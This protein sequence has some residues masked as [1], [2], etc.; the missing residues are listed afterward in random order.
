MSNHSRRHFLSSAAGTIAALSVLGA[1]PAQAE[2][3]LPPLPED[4]P[5]AKALGYVDDVAKVP[6]GEPMLKPDAICAN[7][8]HYKGTETDPV[9]PCALFPGWSVPDRAWCKAWVIKPV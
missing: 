1:G 4:N 8:L 2:T 7:C 6:A 3:E 9:A 5:T